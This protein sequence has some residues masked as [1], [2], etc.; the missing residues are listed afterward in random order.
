MRHGDDRGELIQSSAQ[1]GINRARGLTA[2]WLGKRLGSPGDPQWVCSLNSGLI[3]WNCL[4]RSTTT[5]N[6]L[7]TTLNKY[8]IDYGL[9]YLT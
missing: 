9:L 5:I 3:G 6:T 4:C 7:K 2:D 1:C 8:Y